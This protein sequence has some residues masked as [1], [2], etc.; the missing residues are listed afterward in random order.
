MMQAAADIF[1]GWTH[2]QPDGRCFYVRRLKDLR[3][4]D[5][6]SGSQPPCRS[7][8]RCAAGRWPAATRAPAMRSPI[9]GYHGRRAGFERAIA[10]FAMTYADQ[11][12]KDWHTFRDAI[13][14]GRISAKDG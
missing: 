2:E 8:L 12:E 3:L 9:A 10:E 1:L 4:A 14:A 5:I 7:T 6:G 11:T 13:K